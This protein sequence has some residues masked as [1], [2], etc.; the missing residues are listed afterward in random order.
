MEMKMD[1]ISLRKSD[2]ILRY[3]TI[4]AIGEYSAKSSIFNLA[5]KKIVKKMSP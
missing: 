1:P 4:R 2:L 3:L 5:D